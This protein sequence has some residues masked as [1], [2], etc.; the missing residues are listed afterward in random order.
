MLLFFSKFENKHPDMKE[1]LK[2]ILNETIEHKIE[3]VEEIWN[4]IDE[5]TLPVTD[6]EISVAKER[7][8]EYL[9][10]PSDIVSWE[11]AK[12]KLMNKYGF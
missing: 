3:A 11:E 4:S 6:E 5:A 1:A 7:Y 12:Q 8:E 9:K 2:E 10:N